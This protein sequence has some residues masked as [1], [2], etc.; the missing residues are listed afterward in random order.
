MIE[1]QY[2][3]PNDGF[4]QQLSYKAQTTKLIIYQD[5]SGLVLH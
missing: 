5:K 2:I 3:E 1:K 4:S